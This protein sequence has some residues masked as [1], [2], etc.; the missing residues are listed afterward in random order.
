MQLEFNWKD[1]MDP[2]GAASNVECASVPVSEPVP[3]PV[4]DQE[5]ALLSLH[6]EL[7]ERTGR[8]ITVQV[9]N[10]R[11]T[12]LTLKPLRA[13]HFRLRLHNMFLEA[14]GEVRLA[15]ARWV[16]QPRDPDAGRTIDAFIRE[17]RDDIRPREPR[18]EQVRTQGTHFDLAALYAEVNKTCF[19]HAV[20][21]AITW[22]RMPARRRRRSIRFGSYSPEQNIVRIHP[23][24]DQAFVPAY[25]VRYIVFHEM[26]HALLGIEELPSGRRRIHPPRFCQFEKT[27][28][29]YERACAWIENPANLG[30][31]LHRH[32]G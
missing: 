5:R 28:P 4:P 22:G 7:E 12:M 13:G 19:N 2:G 17:R 32:G 24:L 14:P 16:V 9:T 25:V 8:R 3:A 23:Y 30:R 15:L 26:L 6:S 20:K 21:A 11:S 18:A 29:D 31:L 27:Y 1:R 10:N